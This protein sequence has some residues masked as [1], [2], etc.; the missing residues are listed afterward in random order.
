MAGTYSTALAEIRA[1]ETESSV[2]DCS[3]TLVA[4]IFPEQWTVHG[5]AFEISADNIN[6]HKLYH[7][8]G[9][10]VVITVQPGGTVIVPADIG[11][12]VRFLRL[13]AGEPQTAKREFYAVLLSAS[14][15]SLPLRETTP[16]R[17]R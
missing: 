17:R 2:V 1:G 12:A 14:G 9:H 11:R 4:I 15:G 13:V 16:A 6:Y 8:D 7:M 5:L 3:G 10:D